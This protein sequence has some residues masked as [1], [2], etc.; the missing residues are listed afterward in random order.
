VEAGWF[1]EDAL[2]MSPGGKR[3]ISRW[4]ID[5]YGKSVDACTSFQNQ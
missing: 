4:I 2:P 3:S 1:P 5:T